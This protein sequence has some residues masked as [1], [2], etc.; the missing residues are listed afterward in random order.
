MLIAIQNE[1]EWA[2]FCDGVLQ[3]PDVAEDPRFASSTLRVAHRD[4]VNAV[5]AEVFASLPTPNWKRG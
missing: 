2:R 1:P 3:R 4:V 5:I